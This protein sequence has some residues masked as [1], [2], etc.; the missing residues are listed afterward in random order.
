M[1]KQKRV[2]VIGGSGG[3]GL[4]V[5]QAA[6]AAGAWVAI[7]SRSK[8]KLAH[9]ATTISGTVETYPIDFTH[10]DE[11]ADLFQNKIQQF[12]HLIVSAF[13]FG[14]GLLVKLPISKAKEVFENKFWGAYQAAKY[15]APYLSDSGSITMFSGIMCQRPS[16]GVAAGA[17]AGGAI[18]VLGRALAVELAPIRVNVINPGLVDTPSWGVMSDTD[19]EA[20]F[21]MAREMLPTRR[22][23]QPEDI[24]Q[25]TLA[26]MTNLFITGSVVLI[27][28]GEL[29]SMFPQPMFTDQPDKITS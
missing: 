14:G 29:L 3:I 20:M 10:E 4:A 5:A 6:S 22:I 7:A 19:R 26:I 18:E 24:A 21:A 1:L 8:D 16:A 17:A 12:D 27:D 15:A 9:A 23:A 2:V 25:I 11:V 13:M 28:G